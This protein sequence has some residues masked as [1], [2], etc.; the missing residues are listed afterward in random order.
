[1]V[2]TQRYITC[3]YNVPTV[4]SLS[5]YTCTPSTVCQQNNYCVGNS[6]PERGRTL[7]VTGFQA[8]GRSKSSWRRF[9]YKMLKWY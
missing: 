7:G 8:V 6:P 3:I 1:M 2:K 5:E 9:C 4:M